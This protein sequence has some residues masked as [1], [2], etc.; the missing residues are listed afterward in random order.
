MKPQAEK[1][2]HHHHNVQLVPDRAFKIGISL[3]LL[4]VF[5]EIYYG[6]VGQS[7]ALVSDAL[8][9][10]T[11][12]FGLVIA[13]LGMIL[14]KRAATRRFSIYAAFT[15]TSLLMISSVWV[16]FEAYDRYQAGYAPV[17]TTMMIVAFIGFLINLFSAKLFHHHQHDLNIKSAYLHLMADAAVSLGVLLTGVVI[18]Y[19]SVFWVDPAISALI[20]VV[21]I[22]GTWAVFKESIIMLMGKKPTAINIESIKAVIMNQSEVISIKDIRVWA[23]STSENALSA[24]LELSQKLTDTQV[25]TLKHR[26]FHDFQIAEVTF[27]V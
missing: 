27:R 6:I 12:V 8:H 21:I 3:N 5:I 7:L 24:K 17:A 16:I 1:C 25:D 10:L 9:N 2:D 26:L 23:L 4:F 18:Y 14:S 15:N 11:D 22:W 19:K 13:W 20:S